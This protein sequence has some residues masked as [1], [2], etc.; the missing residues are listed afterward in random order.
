MSRPLP[1][2][3]LSADEIAAYANDLAGLAER[4]RF[5]A[6]SMRQ[7]G[8][9]SVDVQ[10]VSTGK[11]GRKKIASFLAKIDDAIGDCIYDR[12]VN[13]IMKEVKKVKG[14]TKKSVE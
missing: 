3:G 11:E 14:S 4:F 5:F 1:A 2:I 13:A 9:E 8:I 7:H 6:E 12:R 10:L